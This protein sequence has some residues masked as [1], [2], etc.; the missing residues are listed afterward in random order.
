[1]RPSCCTTYSAS[2][3]EV[4]GI[5]EAPEGTVSSRSG[6]GSPRFD[7][8]WRPNMPDTFEKELREHY[9]RP[10]T[11]AT[12]RAR[13]AVR[14]AATEPPRQPRRWLRLSQR[15]GILALATAGLL[16]GVGAFFLGSAF[17]VT[18]AS[19]SAGDAPGFL[20]AHGWTEIS[21][22]TAPLSDG[23]MVI[24]ANVPVAPR[25]SGGYVG[26][27]RLTPWRSCPQTASSFTS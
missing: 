7:K 11:S 21:T 14:S 16:I 2:A 24:A 23:P 9:P 25:E 5:V 15:R 1:M 17:P 12:E 6:A 8:Q 3:C 13:S 4:A 19:S 26:T 18:S 20:P 10:S 27:F 22:G